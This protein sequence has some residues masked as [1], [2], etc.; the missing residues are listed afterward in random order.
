M[1]QTARYFLCGLAAALVA[2]TGTLWKLGEPSAPERSVPHA[3]ADPR[4]QMRPPVIGSP[5]EQRSIASAEG[6][7]EAMATWL[8]VHWAFLPPAEIE[9]YEVRIGA[10]RQQIAQARLVILQRDGRRY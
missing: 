9:Q 10:L 2:T 4:L 7:A 3:H 8:D 6:V 1:N 5:M